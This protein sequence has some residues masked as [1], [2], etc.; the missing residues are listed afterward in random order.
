MKPTSR[1]SQRV[2]PALSDGAAGVPIEGETTERRRTRAEFIS[3][4]RASSDAAKQSGA[5]FPAAQVHAE[6]QQILAQAM[7]RVRK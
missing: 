3:R 5:Y 2:D 4:G 7:A 1:P 6:L